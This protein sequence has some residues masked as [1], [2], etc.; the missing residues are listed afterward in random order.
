MT[1]TA[2]Y[3]SS[4]LVT[5][6]PG[7]ALTNEAMSTSDNITWSI[8]NAAHRYLDP[9]SSP[10][11]KQA[12][13]ELQTVTI[14][15]GPTAGT[16]VLNFGGN[17]TT[18]L[19]WNCTAAQM[20]TALQALP[21]IGANNALVTGGPG[22][23]SAFLVQFTAG[24]GKVNQALMTMTNNLLTGGTTPSVT[25]V[26]TQPGAG[27]GVPTLTG[28][29]LIKA[30]GRVVFPTAQQIG[31]YFRI[32]TGSYLAY[33]TLAEAANCEFAGKF[34]MADATT[35]NASGTHSFVPTTLEGQI[36]T[37]TFWINQTRVSSL[38]ARDLLAYSFVLPS[39][40]RYEGYAYAA[41]LG[42]KYDPKDVVK[43]SLT[44]Q[45]TNEVNAA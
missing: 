4:V 16:F 32:S 7:V 19:N 43:Q 12:A 6:Q 8:T 26:E 3:N 39:G 44:M 45:L 34:T 40:N 17:A 36:K 28:F 22:P 20:Q 29:T 41:D 2:G 31:N 18:P 1:A 10:V 30:G 15:G 5:A 27:F 38:L 21:S 9:T 37:E 24:L 13:D 14:T 42:L 23:S 25:I 35:F 33:S 11:V